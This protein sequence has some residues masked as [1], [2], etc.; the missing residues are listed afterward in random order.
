MLQTSTTSSLLDS[1]TI[2]R[3]PRTF[4]AS[5]VLRLLTLQPSPIS[6]IQ[7]NFS[8]NANHYDGFTT[9]SQPNLNPQQSNSSFRN[10]PEKQYAANASITPVPQFNLVQNPMFNSGMYYNSSGPSSPE[11]YAQEGR[12]HGQRR[13]SP[14]KF[15]PAGHGG[16][17]GSRYPSPDKVNTQQGQAWG[18]QYSEDTS[19]G[20]MAS[21]NE[22]AAQYGSAAGFQYGQSAQFNFGVD[23]PPHGQGSGHNSG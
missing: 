2:I 1:Q 22:P 16:V 4:R 23:F 10:S 20:Q 18:F 19:A 17:S 21:F 12:D 7:T 14:G 8:A 13:R 3:F 9:F 15:I 6:H 11:K 5:R